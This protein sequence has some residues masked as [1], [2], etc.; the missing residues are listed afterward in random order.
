MADMLSS[1]EREQRL[2]RILADYLHAV[3]AGTAPDRASL[4]KQ[5]P[6]LAGELHSFF[7]NRD[8]IEHMAEPIKQQV[9]EMETITPDGAASTGPGSTIRYFGDYELLEEIARG[10]MGVV[11]KARQASLNRVVALKMIL[12]GQL[13]S[14]EEVTRFHTEAEAAGNLDHPN[15]VQIY[16][17]GEHQGQH[18][19]S[20]RFVVGGCLTAKTKRDG[21]RLGK[22]DQRKA[23][24]VVAKVARAVHH[25]HQRGILH[26]DLKPGNILIDEQGQPHVTDFGLAKRVEGDS[27]LTRSGAIVGTPSYMAP[28]QARSEKVLTTGVDVYS[29]GAILYELL[30]GRPPFR[31]ET[32]LDTVLQLLGQEPIAPRSLCPTIDRDLETICL[33]CLQKEPYNRYGSAAEL[34]DDLQRFQAGEPI[35]ARPVGRV[36]RAVKWV[37]RNPVP[38]GAIAAVSLALV[39]GTVV[40]TYFAIE[41]RTKAD[42]LAKKSDDLEKTASDLK[43]SRDEVE[44]KSEVL[45]TTLARS[46]LRPLALE[47]GSKPLTEPEWD[48]LRELATSRPGRLGY[49]FVEDATRAPV[50]SRQLRDRAAQALQAAVGLDLRQRDEVEKLL[51]TR[52]TDPAL[53]AEQKWDLALTLAAWDGLSGTGAVGTARQLVAAMT[54]T[55]DE[56]AFQRRAA[57]PQLAQGLS[58][59]APRLEPRAAAQAVTALTQAMKDTG[60]PAA[61][62]SLAQG[63]S[64]M[65]GRLEPKDAAQAAAGAAAALT[66]AMQ[67][68]KNVYAMQPLVQGLSEVAVRMEPRDAAQAASALTQTMKANKNAYAVV[69]LAQGVSAMAGRLEPKEAAET[70]A[71][72]TQ[73]MKDTKNANAVL[74]LAQSLSPVASRLEPKDAALTAAQATP[75][76]IQAMKNSGSSVNLEKLVQAL[77]KMAAPLEPKEAAQTAVALTQAMTD[78]KSAF[79]AHYLAQSLSAVATRLEPKE[80]VAVLTQAMNDPKNAYQVPQLAEGLAAAATRLEPKEAAAMLT[81]AMKEN[82]NFH[83]F[84]PLAQGLSVVALRLAPNEAAQTAA[85]L[86]QAMKD[87]RNADVLSGLAQGLSAVA[88]KMDPKDAAAALTPAMM[89]PKNAFSLWH[90]AEGLLVATARLEPKEAAQA[91]RQA[92]AAYTQAMKD[93]S[94][95]Y[96]LPQL[97][98]GLSVVAGRLEPNEAAVTLLQ[99]MTDPKYAVALRFLAHGLAAV[100]GRLEPKEAAKAAAVLLQAMKGNK[101]Q[102]TLRQLAQGLAAVAVRLEP[103]EAAQAAVQAAAI[104]IQAMKDTPSASLTQ[105][106]QGLSAVAARLEPKEAAQIAAELRQAMKDSKN[107]FALPQLAQGLSAVAAR[108]EPKETAAILTQ[109]MKDP[110]NAVAL[111][112]LA[113]DLAAVA[114]RL[115]PKE[116]AEAAAILTRAIRDPKNATALP[117][118]AQG[119]SAVT[120]RMEPSEAA[121]AAAILLSALTRATSPGDQQQLAQWFSMVLTG[122]SPAVQQQRSMAATAV[123][124]GQPLPLL[125]FLQSATQSLP[126][127]LSTQ[128]LVELLKMPTCIGEGRRVVLDHLGNRY[129]RRFADQWKFVRYATEER[130]GL[131]FTSP[132]QRPETLAEG[133]P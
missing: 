69:Q 9:P 105:L 13:A 115:A 11:Y 120:A 33:R 99:A 98:E 46:L 47:G 96:L 126:C 55:N 54:A 57:L 3:E 58:V 109:A 93:P 89:D 95:A 122:F 94:N 1:A 72:L 29:L 36:E 107:Q 23:A 50:T 10:G 131:D 84:H 73:A 4:L 38:A 64:A 71:A 37:R 88:V 5:Y 70:A 43:R 121:Q 129:Q 34:A 61:L 14:P 41:A 127:R 7:R 62:S 25:A 66:K 40:S 74:Q 30:T 24:E 39:L 81:R 51:L 27:A 123:A 103:K 79:R 68:P 100:A 63:V 16:E 56:A 53:G 116:A 108:L 8:A 22:D 78:P 2:E 114:G 35:L 113:Q 92:A 86:T 97:A 106:T 82:K 19:F 125:A 110:Q 132:P 15:I 91:A 83:A 77:S 104:L 90:L 101:D 76:L 119:L 117:G 44:K 87:T 6:D 67:D 52:L 124:I 65:S 32:P 21:T 48:A 112:Q 130:L 42:A 60:D 102:Y 17:V 118:L 59:V 45:E 26:R 49:R 28:E 133:Q 20:M 18:Y 31:A 12:A 85:A 128:R 75:A 111:G 80:A